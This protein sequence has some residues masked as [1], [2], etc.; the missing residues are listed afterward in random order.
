MSN[1]P[2]LDMI[3]A[4]TEAGTHKADTDEFGACAECGEHG[5]GPTNTWKCQDCDTEV[6]RFRGEGDVSC[7]CGAQYNACGQRLR[8][9]W[10][11]N[12]SN[13]DDDMDDMEGFERQQLALDDYWGAGDY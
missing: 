3:L 11:G 2:V 8:D 1:Y 9:D 10:R 4:C 12:M 13:Y 7:D 6:F 5:D